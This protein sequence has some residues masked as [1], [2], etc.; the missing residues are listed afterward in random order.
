MNKKTKQTQWD[1]PDDDDD[2]EDDKG[3]DSSPDHQTVVKKEPVEPSQPSKTDSEIVTS[4]TLEQDEVTTTK[5]VL[6]STYTSQGEKRYPRKSDEWPNY[7][8][9]TN[10]I[11][12][13]EYSGVIRGEPPPPGTDLEFLLTAP[14]PPP[15]PIEEEET[16][17]SYDVPGPPEGLLSNGSLDGIDGVAMEDGND[18]SEVVQSDRNEQ[19]NESD[20]NLT[21][22]TIIARPPQIFT[23]NAYSSYYDANTGS[24]EQYQDM[25]PYYS[26]SSADVLNAMETAATGDAASSQQE[27]KKKKKEKQSSGHLKNKNVSNLVQKWQKVKKEVEIEEQ[28]REERQQAI[29]QK[30]DEWKKEHS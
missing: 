15:P 13:T 12:G 3:R 8:A 14:P 19:Y 29:R 20:M 4:T 5:D 17:A 22:P 11:S 23:D 2:E 27:K 24:S 30:L 7:D 16:G 1:Y 10:Y 9:I 6:T 25:G 18:Y 28:E 21:D 26:E